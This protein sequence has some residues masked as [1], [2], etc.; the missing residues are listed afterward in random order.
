MYKQA[1]KNKIAQKG[2]FAWVND[3]SKHVVLVIIKFNTFGLE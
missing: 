3:F 1:I 2:D